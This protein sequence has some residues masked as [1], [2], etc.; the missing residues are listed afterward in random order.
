MIKTIEQKNN[1][2]LIVNKSHFYSYIFPIKNQSEIKKIIED[3]RK[4]H[5]GCNHVAYAFKIDCEENYSDDGE[6]S[7]T[8]GMPLFNLIKNNKLDYV[9]ICV[10]RIFGGKKL[11]TANL[12]TAYGLAA[13]MA[14]K[15]CKIIQIEKTKEIIKEV[16]L[17][18]FS[19]FEKDL[20]KNKINYSCEF[21][22]NKVIVKIN[23]P[24]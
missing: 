12:K 15:E 21:I 24:I 18:E 8:A 10:A 9:L 6:P 23:K 20:K 11:G 2:K 22:D 3:I 7:K 16:S 14:L 17:K 5:K 1:S 13:Q 19:K 4:N